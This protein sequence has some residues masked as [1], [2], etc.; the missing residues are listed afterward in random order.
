MKRLITLIVAGTLALGVLTGCEKTPAEESKIETEVTHRS[1]KEQQILEEMKKS[2]SS[3]GDVTFDEE[4]RYY[5]VVITDPEQLD[6]IRLYLDDEIP[7][8]EINEDA[9]ESFAILNEMNLKVLENLGQGY[10]L[11]LVDPETEA[12]LISISGEI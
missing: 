9:L 3:L 10:T 1:K 5:E 12:I 8:E 4:D 2:Y 7:I 11:A 6:K